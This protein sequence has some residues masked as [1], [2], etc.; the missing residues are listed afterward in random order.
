MCVNNMGTINSRDKGQR[1]ERLFRDLLRRWG[2]DAERGAQREGSFESPD[3]RCPDLKPL[4]FEVKFTERLNLNSAIAQS[5]YDCGTNE[6][7][8]AHKRNR[9]EWF[10]TVKADFF[11][12]LLRYLGFHV[13][14]LHALR[15]IQEEVKKKKPGKDS[16]GAKTEG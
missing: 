4:H 2:F 11:L 1:G 14:L 13:N 7:L 15:D 10:I 16:E 3:V 5:E 6:P 9:G 12:S 8:V